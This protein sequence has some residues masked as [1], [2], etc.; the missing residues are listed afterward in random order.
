M[1]KLN[2]KL[3]HDTHSPLGHS[4]H[5]IITLIKYHLDNDDD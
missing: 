1:Y 4:E 5:E 2:Q 3:T